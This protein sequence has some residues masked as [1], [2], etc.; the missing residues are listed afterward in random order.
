MSGQFKKITG[1]GLAIVLP[2]LAVLLLSS[3][4]T[5]VVQVGQFSDSVYAACGDGALD[6]ADVCDD[7]NLTSG[8]GCSDVCAVEAG[9]ACDGEPS[10][11]L[12]YSPR[13]GVYVAICG[14]GVVE[15]NLEGVEQCDDGKHCVNRDVCTA[16]IDCFGIGDNL[17]IPR[18][19]DG[20][21][22]NCQ[23]EQSSGGFE[24]PPVQNIFI[25]KI[26]AHPEQRSGN[27]NYDTSAYFKIMN[28]DNQ[29]H[30]VLYSQSSLV[31]LDNLGV[32]SSTTQLFSLD[33]GNY[34]I[35]LKAKSH[36][37]LI[38]DNVH[39]YPG[40]NLLNFTNEISS[41]TIGSVVLLA[42]DIDGLG[43][44][45]SSLGDDVINAVDLSILLSAI[46]IS[47]PLGSNRANLNQDT[48]VDQ[49]DLNILLGNLDKEGQK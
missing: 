1:V 30:Q 2:L 23:I 4:Y 28:P 38:L 19:G 39:L 27:N 24:P 15:G 5:G 20:C 7:G 6:G 12:N 48:T 10:S 18:G 22:V 33:E 9:Y 14:N 11:C 31:D 44:S 26:T 29:N 21:D 17:C 42:G 49:L 40:G 37:T 41:P 32:N 3:V 16:D 34:D 35:S 25:S 43:T 13:T 47:D 45:P 36:L 46:G 8:D